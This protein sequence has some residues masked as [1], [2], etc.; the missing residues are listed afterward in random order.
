MKRGEDCVVAVVLVFRSVGSGIVVCGSF[1]YT[2]SKWYRLM[3]FFR[4]CLI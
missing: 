1:E 4:L 2:L 3:L